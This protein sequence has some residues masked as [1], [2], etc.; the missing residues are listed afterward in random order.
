MPLPPRSSLDLRPPPRLSCVIGRL[1][2]R[3]SIAALR[4]NGVAERFSGTVAREID[5][6]HLDRLDVPA[7]VDRRAMRGDRDVL[8]APERMVWRQR[9]GGEDVECSALDLPGIERRQECRLIDDTA[10]RN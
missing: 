1:P 4:V 3:S 7:L 10:A 5:G 8:I 2:S 6:K 9:L